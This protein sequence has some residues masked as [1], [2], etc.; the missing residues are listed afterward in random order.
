MNPQ[1]VTIK[2]Y[3][4]NFETYS[5]KTP[6][7]MSGENLIWMDEFIK[8]LPENGTVFELGSAHGRDARYLRNKGFIVICTDVILQAVKLLQNDEFNACVYDF[9]DEPKT[10]WIN[11]FNG[12][13]ANAV[14]LHAT[15]E[16]F[17]K[18]LSSLGKCLKEGGVFYLTFKFGEGEEIETGKLGG[19]RYFKYYT[20]LELVHIIKK[21]PQFEIINTDETKDGKWIRVL[22]RKNN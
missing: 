6:N 19:E 12:V 2:T 9:R 18:S 21:Y 20:K 8:L 14:Y 4:D 10:E 16:V 5:E 17:E 1:D 3:Q 15:Q 7:E 13:I 11:S 22:F